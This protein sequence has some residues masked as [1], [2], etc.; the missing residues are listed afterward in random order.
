MHESS[1]RFLGETKNP[2]LKRGG[3]KEGPMIEPNRKL[4]HIENYLNNIAVLQEKLA[5]KDIKITLLEFEL[6]LEKSLLS[7][8]KRHYGKPENSVN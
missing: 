6:A 5:C 7:A 4:T 1:R 8:L 3:K 2:S